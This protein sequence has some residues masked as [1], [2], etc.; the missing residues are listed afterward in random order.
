[1]IK[2]LQRKFI[3]IATLSVFAVMLVIV[4]G[5]NLAN[6]YSTNR[7][8]DLLLALLADNEGR[9]PPYDFDDDDDKLYPNEAALA[10]LSEESRFMTRYFV[11][12]VDFQGKIFQLDTSHIAAL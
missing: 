9:F 5:I 4:G 3:V 10:G 7:Q 12:R 8:I 1:M 2:K 6:L 11:A